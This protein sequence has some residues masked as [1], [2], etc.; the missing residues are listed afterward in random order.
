MIDN[1]SPSELAQRAQLAATVALQDDPQVRAQLSQLGVSTGHQ[2]AW[3]LDPN[4]AL[5]L[6]QNT[7]L[8]AQDAAAGVQAGFGQLTRGQAMSLAQQGVTADQA[9]ST[10]SQLG[11][12][13]GLFQGQAGEGSDI[14]QQE[15]LNAAFQGNA[16]AQ[17]RIQKRAAERTAGFKGG[18]GFNPSQTGVTGLGSQT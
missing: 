7:V 13:A 18:A 12:E 8:A 16:Q 10:F 6:I 5:P 15:Q 2:I 1:V 9:R 11:Q 4:R 14:S 3:I 17:L